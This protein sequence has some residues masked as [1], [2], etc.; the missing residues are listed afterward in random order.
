[1]NWRCSKPEGGVKATLAQVIDTTIGRKKFYLGSE[2]KMGQLNT[3]KGLLEW[4]ER[5]GK[6]VVPTVYL[7]DQWVQQHLEDKELATLLDIPGSRTL[8]LDKESMKRLGK[9]NLPGKIFNCACRGFQFK[10]E[11]LSPEEEPACNQSERPIKCLKY[12]SDIEEK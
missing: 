7:K 2:V 1:M 9:M 4:N 3:Y 5:F 12:S 11:P 10:S 6:V 8:N